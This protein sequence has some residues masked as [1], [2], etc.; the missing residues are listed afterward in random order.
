MKAFL[1]EVDP[2]AYASIL[3]SVVDVEVPPEPL[4]VL[5][6][7]NPGKVFADDVISP[8]FLLIWSQGIEGFYMT[9][10]AETP[11]QKGKLDDA[12]DRLIEPMLQVLGYDEL[13]MS[14]FG[15]MPQEAI[16]RLIDRPLHHW[17][18]LVFVHPKDKLSQNRK[19]PIGYTVHDMREVSLESFASDSL[20]P[21]LET[22][23]LH[24]NSIEAFQ[25]KG[26]GAM[27]VCNNQ[28][29]GH[30]LIGFASDK[31]QAMVVHTN[32]EHWRRNIGYVLSA[33]VISQIKSMSKVP[34]WDCMESNLASQ[35]LANA[36]GFRHQSTY[37]CFSFSLDG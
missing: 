19:L 5:L 3:K 23:R 20:C 32:A 34:Y 30:C 14:V 10:D 21:L 33:K 12:L 27:A 13:E 24:W 22:I 28:I 25:E 8:S 15:K 1:Q 31:M 16:T 4:S 18:Q 37:N 6:R 2:Y 26:L 9:G 36:L 29:V 11:R 35:K 17:R 7:N